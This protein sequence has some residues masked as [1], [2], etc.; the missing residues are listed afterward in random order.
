[1]DYELFQQ[2]IEKSPSMVVITNINGEFLYV[3]PKFSEVTGYDIDD[4]RGKKTSLMKSGE[5][6][7]EYYKQMW[8]ALLEGKEWK[9][10]FHNKKKDGTLYWISSSISSVKDE[11]GN[12][13]RFI[14]VQEEITVIKEAQQKITELMNSQNVILEAIPEGIVIIN[15]KGLIEFSNRTMQDLTLFSPDDLSDSKL[16]FSYLVDSPELID[17]IIKNIKPEDKIKSLF[18]YELHL[19][20]KRGEPFPVKIT[21]KELTNKKFLVVVHDIREE[22]RNELIMEE[23]YKIISN[24]TYITLFRQ[25]KI[26]PEIYLSDDLK[27]SK[28]DKNILEAKVGVYFTTAIGQGGNVNQGLFGP[29]PFPDSSEYISLIYTCFMKDSQ[30][31]DPRSNGSSYCLFVVTFPNK[32]Q[33]YYSNRSYLTQIFSDFQGRFE[34][35]QKIDKNH[36]SELKLNLIK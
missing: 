14:A 36:L 35:I 5:L 34:S 17:L 18:E 15:D 21:I 4:I 32:F 31:K 12:I 25:S 23:F 6:S 10:E 24:E 19:I 1:M 33:P 8:T 20:P 26:G 9:G 13:L 29:L 11:S 28:T 22:K 16:N 3:N 7:T 30:N 27:F 2:A